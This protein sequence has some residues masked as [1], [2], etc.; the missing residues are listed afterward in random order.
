VAPDRKT[1]PG[2]L[3]PWEMLAKNGIGLWPAPGAPTGDFE[4][5]LAQFGYG[6]LPSIPLEC[7]TTAFQRHFRPARV[8]GIADAECAAIL[9][10]LLR[11]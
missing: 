3:F 11:A 8:D 9:A 10:G 5:A 6:V 1:D 2:E 4:Q 7:V